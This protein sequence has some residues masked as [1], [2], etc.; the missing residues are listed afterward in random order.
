MQMGNQHV[1]RCSP[2]ATIRETEVKTT[3]RYHLTQASMAT[4][5]QT[6][7]TRRWGSGEKGRWHTAGGKAS[8][9]SARGKQYPT[10]Q[11]VHAWA[12]IGKKQ[13]TRTWKDTRIPVSAAALFTTAIS[14]AETSVST[15]VQLW[16]IRVSNAWSF[17]GSSSV[18]SS[19]YLPR[20]WQQTPRAEEHLNICQRAPSCPLLTTASVTHQLYTEVLD[21]C[22][23]FQIKSWRLKE[24]PWVDNCWKWAMKR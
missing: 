12:C 21:P 6:A 15:S 23:N 2:S 24:R 11:H 22:R 10:T 17:L 3:A 4:K 18:P 1:Q 14:C 19:I 20:C 9:C 16:K 7:N 8:W 13:K 5:E